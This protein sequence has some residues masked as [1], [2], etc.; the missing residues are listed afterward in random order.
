FAHAYQKMLAEL[1]QTTIKD[2]INP[3]IKKERI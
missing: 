1:E 2:I 3:E